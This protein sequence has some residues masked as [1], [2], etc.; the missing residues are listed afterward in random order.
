MA[1]YLI[2]TNVV[3]RFCNASDSQHTLAGSAISHLLATGNECYLTAQ[4]LIELWVVATRP[5]NVNG[6]GWTTERTKSII[7]DSP[8]IFPCWLA[9]VTVKEILGKRAHDSR[10]VSI[11]LTS[12]VTHLLTFNGKDFNISENITIVH[13]QDC[14][15]SSTIDAS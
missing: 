4:V 8:Q 3:L 14:L 13:P 2:D 6:L 10:L 1:K 15:P 12:K 7:E 5:A 9:L 11:M